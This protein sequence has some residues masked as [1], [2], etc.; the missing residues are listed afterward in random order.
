MNRNLITPNI[1]GVTVYSDKQLDW[2]E[3]CPTDHQDPSLNV[4]EGISRGLIKGE[5]THPEC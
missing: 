5:E 2:I 3:D 1:V 4:D